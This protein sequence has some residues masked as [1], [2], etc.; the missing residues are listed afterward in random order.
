MFRRI[1]NA[2]GFQIRDEEGFITTAMGANHVTVPPDVCKRQLD[3]LLVPGLHR[4]SECI[5]LTNVHL[6]WNKKGQGIDVVSNTG[7]IVLKEFVIQ[8]EEGGHSF[9]VA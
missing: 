8:E 9:R 5:M 2:T 3:E 4:G 1:I 6:N 7:M